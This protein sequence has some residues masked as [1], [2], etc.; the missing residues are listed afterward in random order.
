[1]N[2]GSYSSVGNVI[3]H[4]SAEANFFFDPEAAH[5]VISNFKNV[6]VNPIEL[7]LETDLSQEISNILKL[8]SVKGPKHV[9]KYIQTKKY[10]TCGPLLTALSVFNRSIAPTIAKVYTEVVSAGHAV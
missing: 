8:E 4:P 7:T 5:I 9:L 1:M 3:G 6:Y 10:Q 2:G